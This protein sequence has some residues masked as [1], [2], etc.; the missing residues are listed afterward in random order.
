MRYLSIVTLKA[1][2]LAAYGLATIFILGATPF[3][4]SKQIGRG[5]T[6][7][8]EV[9]YMHFGENRCARH[10]A[11][12][13]FHNNRLAVGLTCGAEPQVLIRAKALGGPALPSAVA[14]R[15]MPAPAISRRA[16]LR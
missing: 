14:S 6:W 1:R 9:L 5:E 2:S 12:L 10:D 13:Q 4:A 11:R 15:R 16:P 7:K 8:P 3:S